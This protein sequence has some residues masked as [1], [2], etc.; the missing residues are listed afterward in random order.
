MKI[1]RDDHITRASIIISILKD[2]TRTM[3]K[4]ASTQI[5]EQFGKDPF[6]ILISC[7]LS[8]RTKDTVSLPAS[9]RL[10]I[11]ARTPQAI[12]DLPIKTLETIIYPVA[13]YH[14]RAENLHA[15]SRDIRDRFNGTV[16]N[17]EAEL[18]TINGVGRKTANLV[19]A[20]AFDMP[21]ICVDTHVHRIANR[22]GLV[23][24]KTPEQTEAA[25]KLVV[26]QEQWREC[27]RLL[28]MWGQNICVPI[29]PKCSLC[30]LAPLCP[31]IG[32]STSR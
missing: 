24:T 20:E 28:V 18:L 13:F 22:L 5:I 4:P 11:V 26:P 32:V 6:L 29:S 21:A 14:K 3:V 2:A 8:L 16:P 17:N 12:L 31:R 10:F 19:L 23:K 25:L 9:Q 7:L 1:L 30:P 27:N 15:V